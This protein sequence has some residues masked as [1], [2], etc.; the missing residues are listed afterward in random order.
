[1]VPR[2]GARSIMGA[3]SRFAR[4]V[5][6]VAGLAMAGA[7]AAQQH[8]PPNSLLLVAKPEL[9]D[10]N[11]RRTVVLVTQAE[12][13]ST[14]GVILNRPLGTRLS[15][16]LPEEAASANYREPVFFGG[17]VM[18]RAIVALFRSESPPRA[19]AFHVLRGVYLTM[20]PDNIRRLLADPARRYRLYAGFS[21]WAPRQLEG[22][23]ARDDW[24][25]LPADEDA[26]FRKNPEGLWE[27]LM[28]KVTRP[29][30]QTRGARSPALAETRSPALGGALCPDPP[31]G[32]ARAA[33]AGSWHEATS[34]ARRDA[35]SFGAARE[36][37]RYPDGRPES[38]ATRLGNPA[39]VAC[40]GFQLTTARRAVQYALQ[41]RANQ[42][43]KTTR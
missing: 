23:F 31:G 10:P 38:R 24:H 19:P 15:E 25:V 12:D 16:L 40:S 43:C 11:F 9:A 3:M 20:H 42:V 33:L 21:G 32:A 28:R 8:E 4:T 7:A 37:A 5:G 18:R 27:E 22:E 35:A 34:G 1:M 36:F 41:A 26:V 39:A 29:K 13:A 30:P 6:L 2:S 17:P 14:V